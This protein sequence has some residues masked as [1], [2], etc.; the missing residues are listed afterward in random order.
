MFNPKNEAYGVG[1]TSSAVPSLIS[2]A[3][4]NTLIAQAHI[5]EA[6]A[7]ASGALATFDGAVLAALKETETALSTYATE[8]DHHAA[9]ARARDQAET[10]FDLARKQFKDGSFSYLDLLQAEATA[11]AAEQAMAASDQALASD[12]VG[13]FQALG[14]GWEQAPKV[15]PPPIAGVTPKIR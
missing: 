5:R 10:A 2:W 4:P 3:F 6:R 12:Q 14:G 8:I 7:Q 13:V 1:P 15:I 9:L 11:I